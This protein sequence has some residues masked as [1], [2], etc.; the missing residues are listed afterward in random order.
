MAI[1]RRAY[2]GEMST[3]LDGIKATGS[4]AVTPPVVFYKGTSTFDCDC[5]TTSGDVHVSIALP[6]GPQLSSIPLQSITWNRPSPPILFSVNDADTP[7][8][9]VKTTASAVNKKLI[10]DTGVIVQGSLTGRAI[11]LIPAANRA[12][13]TTVIVTA[14]DGKN[15]ATTSFTVSVLRRR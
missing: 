1:S 5:I 2:G 9:D 15:T 4:V 13:T 6:V 12:G 11:T 10:P 7:I 3:T 8:Q 14:T